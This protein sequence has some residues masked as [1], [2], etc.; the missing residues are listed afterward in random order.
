MTSI[1]SHPEQYWAAA[2]RPGPVPL[3]LGPVHPGGP[4]L[5]D[6]LMALFGLSTNADLGGANADIEGD[7]TDRRAHA[8]D[9]ARKFSANEANAAEQMQG[10]GAQ[11]MA[12]DGVRHRRSAQRRARRRH[13]A[14]DPAPATGDA[15]RAGRHAAADECNATG[16]RR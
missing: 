11:G 12:A 15:S 13:G 14:A 16:P 4:T 2:G 5:I 7:D 1:E 6:L 9:A 10:V 3:A 8:A